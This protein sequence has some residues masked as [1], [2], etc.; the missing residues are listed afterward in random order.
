[1]ACSTLSLSQRS[2]R[3][4]VTLPALPLLSSFSLAM[5]VVTL[6]SGCDQVLGLNPAVLEQPNGYVC[7]CDCTSTAAHISP[8]T[9]TD[10]VCVPPNLNTILSGAHPTQADLQA[11]CSG[12]VQNN[13]QGIVQ[14]CES[15]T[16]NCSCNV[17]VPPAPLPS[18]F[19]TPECDQACNEVDLTTNCSNWDTFSHPP[20]KTAT[21][22]PGQPP[23]CS[24]SSSDPA[25]PTPDPLVAG[26]FG[27][28]SNCSVNG[29]VTIAHGSDSQ[30][31]NAIGEVNITGK[32]CPGGSCNVGMYYRLDH[33]DDFSFSS[34][35]GF[36][37]VVFQHLLASGTTNNGA[38]ALDA[39]GNGTFPANTT[40]SFGQGRRSNQIAGVEVSSGESGYT[41]TN[42]NPV[43]LGVDWQNHVC[44][45]SGSLFGQV[46]G[47]GTNITSELAGTII[48]EPPTANA[49]KVQTVE[50]T[51]PTGAQVTLDGSGSSDPENNIAA[52]IWHQGTRTGPEVGDASV[53]QVNQGM[54]VSQ[55][56]FLRVIDAY[57]QLDED[58]TS[59]KVVD[60]TPPIIKHVTAA[61]NILWPPNGQLVAVTVSVSAADTCDPNPVCKIAQITSNESITAAEAQITG[62][63]TAN[64]SAERFGSGSGRQYNI[65]VQCTDGSGNSSTGTTT[66][67]V[68]HNQPI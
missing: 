29:T 26:V 41:G 28:T 62:N 68:P 24:V 50:C 56:Y 60:T 13:I 48:N 52:F 5:L 14:H 3:P 55:D 51:S 35:A 30:T 53:V 2:V 54:G 11:D 16:L 31:R 12:R 4:R 34:F 9:V 25:T 64:L 44:E 7:Q 49:G 66:V 15:L 22:I 19:T 32:P 57:G 23:V 21:N 37:S 42:S 59:V 17:V 10:S 20:S 47:A 65:T 61:P 43:A 58:K 63:F 67:T 39:T 6:S 1:M 33:I 45:V 27:H 38:G 36:D 18:M 40:Q 46:E 8:I